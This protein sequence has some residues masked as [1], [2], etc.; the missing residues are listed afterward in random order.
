[1]KKERITYFLIGL[2]FGIVFAG[3]VSV[4]FYYNK[5]YKYE[6]KA[7]M[8]EKHF[9]QLDSLF[10]QSVGQS[11]KLDTLANFFVKKA[12]YFATY[13]D[14]LKQLRKNGTTKK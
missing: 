1:M 8:A 13:K 5:I 4:A 14:S 2:F 10:H 11:R 9:Y 3:G 6:Q 7:L 12:Y